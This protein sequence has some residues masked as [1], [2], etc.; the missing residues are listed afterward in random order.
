MVFSFSGPVLAQ[1]AP[2]HDLVV[3]AAAGAA[4]PM[5]DKAR[6]IARESPR[7]AGSFKTTEEV[8]FHRPAGAGPAPAT[9]QHE[10]VDVSSQQQNGATT[11]EPPI[12]ARNPPKREL[13]WL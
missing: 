4:S 12:F 6:T 3:A 1:R 10:G 2:F 8:P 11:N 13:Y 9:L 5:M 7:C